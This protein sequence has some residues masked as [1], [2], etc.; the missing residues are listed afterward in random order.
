MVSTVSHIN[1]VELTTAI[2]AATT[3]TSLQH[4]H[5]Q[6]LPKSRIVCFATRRKPPNSNSPP[7]PYVEFTPESQVERVLA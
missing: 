1:E 5:A 3:A 4:R 7:S 2:D 6:E